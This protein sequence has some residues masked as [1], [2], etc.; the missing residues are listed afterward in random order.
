MS[1]CGEVLR[2]V[3]TVMQRLRL[4][5]EH[6]KQVMDNC[7]T[8]LRDVSIPL[9]GLQFGV[10]RSRFGPA[11]ETPPPPRSQKVRA[12][13]LLGLRTGSCSV[14]VAEVVPVRTAEE[15][16]YH[17]CFVNVRRVVVVAVVGVRLRKK[18][19]E[20]GAW[21]CVS[22][23]YITESGGRECCLACHT[24]AALQWE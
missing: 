23:C 21:V 6:Q 24:T 18:E 1:L 22:T 9:E 11:L 15:P 10:G 13:V 8:T 14:A 12:K 2:G 4:C 20:K 5:L 7:L 17:Y 16:R 19:T 3:E